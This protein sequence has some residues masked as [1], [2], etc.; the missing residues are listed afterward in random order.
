[1]D[2]KGSKLKH[3]SGKLSKCCY[4]PHKVHSQDVSER[5]L[6]APGRH[7]VVARTSRSWWLRLLLL[8]RAYQKRIDVVF[9]EKLAA[10]LAMP[11]LRLIDPTQTL[12][13]RPR[14]MNP[15]DAKTITDDF[16]DK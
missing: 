13:S 1:M 15:P 5:Q 7:L 2:K 9:P 14:D 3:S 16:F 6:S 4:R 11:R 10:F 8:G 12:E